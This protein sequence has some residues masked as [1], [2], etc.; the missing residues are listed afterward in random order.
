MKSNK[1]SSTKQ[2]QTPPIMEFNWEKTARDIDFL[3]NNTVFGRIPSIQSNY[4]TFLETQDGSD[5]KIYQ[6]IVDTELPITGPAVFG[7]EGQI[8]LRKNNFPY[9]F[10]GNRHYLLWIHPGCSI[11]LKNQIFT[12]KGINDVLDKLLANGPENIKNADRIIFRNSIQNK[13]V[14]LVE[15]FHIVFRQDN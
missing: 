10:G 9:N 6:R 15:H 12:K 13:S 4:D 11:A 14:L 7:I 5:E 1:P 2:T 8:T 3:N